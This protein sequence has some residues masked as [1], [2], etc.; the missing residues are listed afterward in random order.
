MDKVY[1]LEGVEFEWDTNKAKSNLE[2]HGVSFEEAAEVFFD[3][4]YQ[5]GDATTNDELRDFILGYS[6]SQRLLLVV[7]VERGLR[8]RII[9]SRPATRT[10][11]Q[12]YE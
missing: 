11:R 3:P 1:R 10:E 2:K 7:Y 8:N 5:E 4:F 9:S 12:L 6:L